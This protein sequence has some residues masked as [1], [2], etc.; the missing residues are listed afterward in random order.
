MRS[1]HLL[2]RVPTDPATAY[3]GIAAFERYAEF[4]DDVRQVAVGPTETSWEVNFRRG[5]MRWH[6]TEVFDA[7]ALR[8][9][10]TQTDGD[11]DDFRGSWSVSAT[12]DGRA[13]VRFEVT[14]DFG[15][16]S[17]SGLMDPIAERVIKRA[18]VQVLGGLFGA[19][20]VLEGGAALADLDP[21]A[22]GAQPDLTR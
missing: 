12:D 7:D 8:I 16:E 3:S 2:V 4:A 14:Y 5:L 6:E 11:F 20:E 9:E 17:L 13:E 15:I 18:I 10:F 1:I 21:V 22:A 19:A